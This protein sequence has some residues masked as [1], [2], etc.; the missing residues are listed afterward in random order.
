LERVGDGGLIVNGV[1]VNPIRDSLANINKFNF[2][3]KGPIHFAILSLIV[4]LPVFIIF[5]FIV[6][7]RTRIK[8][9]KWL[10]AIFVLLGYGQFSFNWTTGAGGIKP[11]YVQLL[12]AG[13]MSAGKY[14]PWIFSISFPLGAILFW[15]R[16]G[17]M[18]KKQEAIEG[19]PVSRADGEGSG[20]LTG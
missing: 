17:E 12:G 11:F 10:W 6:C 8:R 4:F 5:T 13:F 14:A 18:A 19:Q 1:N 15:V 20:S 7:L 9:R 2:K 3:G 16:R